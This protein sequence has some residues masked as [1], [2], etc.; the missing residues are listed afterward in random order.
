MTDNLQHLKDSQK[1]SNPHTERHVYFT[2]VGTWAHRVVKLKEGAAKGKARAD[3]RNV[4]SYRQD[5]EDEDLEQMQEIDDDDYQHV[6]Q[7]LFARIIV[8]EA[9]CLKGQRTKAH[10]A[11]VEANPT[12]IVL[13]TGTPI[14]NRLSDFAGMLRILWRNDWEYGNW[15]V[16]A[17]INHYTKG[18]A[19]MQA[20]FAG[21]SVQEKWMLRILWKNS[22]EFEDWDVDASPDLYTTG[23]ESMEKEF[24]GLSVEEKLSS[25]HFSRFLYLINLKRSLQ[26]AEISRIEG[27]HLPSAYDT[28]EDVNLAD[29]VS[30]STA[31]AAMKAASAR[32]DCFD[33]L[34]ETAWAGFDFRVCCRFFFSPDTQ[35]RPL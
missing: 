12:S 28:A 27:D 11:V 4:E 6:C 7:D 34:F 23:T 19:D 25:D 3:A 18:M 17:T 9:H 8:D 20:A 35:S 15:E 29:D 16:E 13:M 1:L 24:A 10:K 21:I 22:W 26:L 30:V 14:S 31:S 33:A 32:E 5:A 2:T